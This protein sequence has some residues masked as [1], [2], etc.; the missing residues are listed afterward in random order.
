MQLHLVNDVVI[1]MLPLPLSCEVS[2]GPGH[3]PTLGAEQE[4]RSPSI[5]THIQHV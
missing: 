2:P 4:T 5:V 3:S 1:S